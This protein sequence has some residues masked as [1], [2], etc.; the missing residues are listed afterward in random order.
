MEAASQLIENPTP[1]EAVS[2]PPGAGHF[3]QAED[4]T[5]VKQRPE[6]TG[7]PTAAPHT[8]SEKVFSLRVCNMDNEVRDCE[9]VR[10]CCGFR[11]F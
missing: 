8:Q 6:S 3:I 5:S 1:G 11:Y 2:V 4:G 7:D 9:T 10:K